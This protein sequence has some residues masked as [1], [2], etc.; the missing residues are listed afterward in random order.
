MVVTVILL[1]VSLSVDALAVG[2]AYGLRNVRIPLISKIIICFFSILY[3]GGALM[4][5]RSLASILPYGIAKASGI[6]ILV[7]MGI[8]T[9]VRALFGKPEKAS[10]S[11]PET[12]NVTLANIVIKSL[13]I[14]INVVKNPSQGDIDS[15]G[16]IDIPESLL[17]GFA[18]SVDAIGAGIGSSL[19]GLFS[20]FVPFSIGAFQLLFLYAGTYIGNRV[21]LAERVN[22][23]ALALLPGIILL[24][25][26]FVRLY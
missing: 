11:R 4:A 25:L 1:A 10:R 14:T 17:L 26:A 21:T 24:L 9:I 19:A 8:W 18:L 3:S 16:V 20:L 12:G 23:K 22:R 2:T 5:G 6:I 13:G 7:V 15:S